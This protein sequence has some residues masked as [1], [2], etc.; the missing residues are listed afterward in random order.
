MTTLLQRVHVEHQGTQ[1]DKRSLN[2]RPA[3][4]TREIRLQESQRGSLNNVKTVIAKTPSLF[5]VSVRAAKRGLVVDE[6]A[7][8][9]VERTALG[10]ILA[11]QKNPVFPPV[12]EGLPAK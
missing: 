2:C 12:G 3:H 5:V 8:G 4:W 6:E 9:V 11:C 1:A 10:W 7:G